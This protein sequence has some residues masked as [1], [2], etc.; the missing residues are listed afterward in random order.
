LPRPDPLRNI[1]LRSETAGR[2]CS[3]TSGRSWVGLLP[4]PEGTP[5]DETAARRPLPGSRIP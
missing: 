3:E 5:A 2:P 4:A 1:F